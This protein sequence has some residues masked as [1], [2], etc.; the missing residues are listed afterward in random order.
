M[1]TSIG[2]IIGYDTRDSV[3]KVPANIV[4]SIVRL[5]DNRFAIF[6]NDIAVYSFR[7]RGNDIFYLFRL[8]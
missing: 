2:I 3:G 7:T 6:D 8:H 1:W 4:E 5:D